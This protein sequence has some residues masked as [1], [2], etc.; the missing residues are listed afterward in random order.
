MTPGEPS[1]LCAGYVECVCV[2]SVCACVVRGGARP[3]HRGGLLPVFVPLGCPS[4]VVASRSRVALDGASSNYIRSRE[5]A[6]WDYCRRNGYQRASSEAGQCVNPGRHAGPRARVRP[7]VCGWSR[8]G[9]FSGDRTA[10]STQHG[11]ACFVSSC[12]RLLQALRR[13]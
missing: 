13:L 10:V 8:S 6:V 3:P 7:S 11:A 12:E 5:R 9:R 2:W 4:G 1:T